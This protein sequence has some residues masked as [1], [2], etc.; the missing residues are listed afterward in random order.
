WV[1]AGGVRCV[2]V[3][4]PQHRGNVALPCPHDCGSEIEYSLTIR[5]RQDGEVFYY[6]APPECPGCHRELPMLP[7]AHFER[8]GDWNGMTWLRIVPGMP[9]EPTVEIKQR[10]SD[11]SDKVVR[12]LDVK[13]T[14]ELIGWHPAWDTQPAALPPES[15]RGG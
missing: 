3:D 1:P 9:G 13:E 12:S 5:T 10:G 4:L 8:C 14:R 2:A 6:Q 7:D 11:S 15:Q